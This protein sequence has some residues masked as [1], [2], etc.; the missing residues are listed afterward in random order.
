VNHDRSAAI[1]EE[2]I[3]TVTERDTHRMQ[4]C[5]TCTISSDF[6]IQHITSVKTIRI[7]FAVFLRV[8]IKMPTGRGERWNFAL[9]HGMNV[10]SVSAWRQLLDIH[11]NANSIAG[12]HNSS[13]A[14]LIP[15]GVYD[16]CVR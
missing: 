7:V 16:I 12:G 15:L 4:G 3:R 13:S 8:R 1:V 14:N 9:S 11:E 10:N 6:E 2:R 5:F